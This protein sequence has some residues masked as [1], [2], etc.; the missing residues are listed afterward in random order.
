MN[1]AGLNFSERPL[2]EHKLDHN[3][4]GSH[5]HTKTNQQNKTKKKMKEE[6]DHADRPFGWRGSVRGHI[7][8]KEAEEP[9]R[10]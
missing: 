6:A 10:S 7:L 5:T 4:A 3:T 8:A 9:V 1:N 2:R